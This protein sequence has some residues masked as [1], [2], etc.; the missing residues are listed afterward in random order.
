MNPFELVETLAGKGVRLSVEGGDLK[1]RGPKWAL[2]PE[3][4]AQLKAHKAEVL[5]TLAQPPAND[6]VDPPKLNDESL[7]HWLKLVRDSRRRMSGGEPDP[8]GDRRTT[9]P[10]GETPSRRPTIGRGSI[11][12]RPPCWPT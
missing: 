6:P 10:L 11:R 7:E 12:S 3:T 1:C 5:E 9:R 2:T 8:P 4:L